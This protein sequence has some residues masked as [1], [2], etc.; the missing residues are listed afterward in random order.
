M[1]KVIDLPTSTSM[2]DSDYLIMESSGGGTKKISRWNALGEGLNNIALGKNVHVLLSVPANGSI[3]INL[4][5]LGYTSA[6]IMG[7]VNGVG[8]VLIGLLLNNG[9]VT[10]RNLMNNTTW[11]NNAITF[12]HTP[13]A[14]LTISNTTSGVH[15]IS[16]YA[17]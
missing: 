10:A 9:T 2:S 14:T 7:T 11:T 1:P 8:G 6:I 17:G 3:S 5:N 13:P 4:R 16:V 12:T 15:Y